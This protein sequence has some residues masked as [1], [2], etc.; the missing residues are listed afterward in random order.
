[1]KANWE[2]IPR[3]DVMPQ[4]AGIY[5]TMN[6]AGNI[7]M[8]RVTYQMMDEP[9]AFLIL[10][11]KVNNRIGLKP[12]RM[13]MKNA[14]P[15][16]VGSRSGAKLVRAHRLTRE[17]RIILPHTVQFYDAEINEDGIL[18][19]DLRTAK[20]SPRALGHARNKNQGA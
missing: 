20:P 13:S 16:R 18:V 14:Y 6:P 19:L 9:E 3:G 10:Y 11:D 15:A 1:M 12:T 2:E 17:R 8:S 5:V 4:Y 7:V